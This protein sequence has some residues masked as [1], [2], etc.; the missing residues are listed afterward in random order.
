MMKKFTVTHT[1]VLEVSI[2]NR[3]KKINTVV[4]F[5][6]NINTIDKDLV[7]E[8]EINTENV[9]RLITESDT[10]YFLCSGEEI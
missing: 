4:D 2:N 8:R 10:N 9:P 6:S 5:G 3:Q 7:P 1:I